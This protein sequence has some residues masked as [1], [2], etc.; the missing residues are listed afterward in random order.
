MHEVV[1]LN[2]RSHLSRIFLWQ[3]Q[4]ILI[5]AVLV[6]LEIIYPYWTKRF[7]QAFIWFIV[8]H[9]ILVLALI[10]RWGVQWL[11]SLLKNSRVITWALDKWLTLWLQLN[12]AWL[13]TNRLLVWNRGFKNSSLE[14][15]IGLCRLEW[16]VIDLMIAWIWIWVY[17]IDVSFRIET[18]LSSTSNLGRIRSFFWRASALVFLLPACWV[19]WSRTGPSLDPNLRWY[20]TWAFPLCSNCLWLLID[21]NVVSKLNSPIWTLWGII[22]HGISS[23]EL[24]IS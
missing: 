11:I 20:F 19:R 7:L 2:R 3:H 22:S 17:S 16:S 1:L 8:L 21:L 15:H 18:G 5:I 24:L 13:V 23:T 9:L 14:T 4:Y 6:W 12:F 10:V